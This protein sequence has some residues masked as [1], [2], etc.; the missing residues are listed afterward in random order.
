MNKA[1]AAL[2]CVA[3][4]ASAS[5]WAQMTPVGTWRSMDEKENTPKA[6]VKISE[7]GGVVTGKVEALLRKGADPNQLC[8]ECKDELKDKPMV[9]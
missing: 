2:F 6:Q 8:T 3:T 7:S 1:V 9:G 4:L 5:A